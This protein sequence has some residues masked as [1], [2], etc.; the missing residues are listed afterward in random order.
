MTADNNSTDPAA[1]APTKGP[2]EK[3]RLDYH[4]EERLSPLKNLVFGFQWL[5]LLLPLIV[6]S[7]AIVAE[8]AGYDAEATAGF[9]SKM[10]LLCGAAMVIQVLWG[11]GLPLLDG[12]AAVLLVTFANL[13]AGGAGV[14]Y[15]LGGMIVGGGIL[16]LTALTPLLRL[17]IKLFT[18]NVVASILML[19]TFT[20]MPLIAPLFAGVAKAQPGGDVFGALVALLLTLFM[21]AVGV[22]SK[23]LMR[24]LSLFMGIVIGVT[25]MALMGRV[26]WQ[27]V[28]LAGWLTTPPV[29]SGY[30]LGLGLS[31]AVAFAISYIAVAIN[32]VG[33]TTSVQELV[34]G[35]KTERRT[36]RGLFF[37]GVFGVAGGLGGVIGTVSYSIS[38]GVIQI[39]RVGSRWPMVACGLITAALAFCPKIAAALS[40][41][42]GPV[43]GAALVVIMAGQLSVALQLMTSG[44]G[45]TRRRTMVVGLSTLTGALVAILP[46][47]FLSQIPGPIRGL[48]GN[49]LVVGIILALLL[50]HVILRGKD[51]PGE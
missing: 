46:Q 16:A 18:D 21:A 49:G 35:G 26:N 19:L 15:A 43:V 6:I 9:L 50:E 38:P 28:S 12:P 7:A 10:L 48:A 44:P 11:H 42:P 29:G 14:P 30:R 34:G 40:M 22:R 8:A 3:T 4:L 27:P 20:L 23:G 45:V 36:V 32:Q 33:S 2:A 47:A 41:V 25:V 39:T 5:F 17:L 37:C 1:C 51:S 24:S 31:A 13:A